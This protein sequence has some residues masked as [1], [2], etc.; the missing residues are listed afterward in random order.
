MAGHKAGKDAYPKKPVCSVYM[1]S[2]VFVPGFEEGVYV[3]DDFVDHGVFGLYGCCQ[4]IFCLV[5][6][7]HRAD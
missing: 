1:E 2:V 3:L 5:Y 6:C 4:G 7:F